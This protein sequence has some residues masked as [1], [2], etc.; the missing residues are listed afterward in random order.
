MARIVLGLG[1]SH[2]PMLNMG[3]E[4]WPGYEAIER[5]GRIP[6]YDRQGRPAAFDALVA[7]ADPRM[8]DTIAPAER[9]RRHDLT[10]AAIA[11]LGTVLDSAALDA[12]I[13]VGDDQKEMFDENNQPAVAIYHGETIRNA[14][15]VAEPGRLPFIVRAYQRNCETS[16][17]REYPV[18]AALAR[19]LVDTLIEREV[20][21]ATAK[22]LPRDMG[23]GHAFGFVHKR[24]MTGRVVPIV[25]VI[26]NTFYPPNQPTPRRCYRL[27]QEIAAAVASF[28]G[29][30]RVGIMAS[31]GLS[32][33]VI[34]EELDQIVIAAL[35]EKD[36]ATLQSLPRQRL[37]A[38]SSEIRNWICVAGAV[39]HLALDWIEYVPCYRTLAGTGTAMGFASWC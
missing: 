37:E 26:F 30:A 8:A 19:H 24:V 32:H 10:E 17:T 29:E 39:E 36:A 33:F 20:D 9:A 38:G 6:L 28:P 13:V 18:H 27:G 23:E 12:L 35:R 2:S 31:G 21:V 14:P 25:P 5:S 15:F 16:G 22:S 7:T 4:D 11:R 3:A 1:S 34:D